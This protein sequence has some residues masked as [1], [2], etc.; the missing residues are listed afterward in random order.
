MN[1]EDEPMTS[2]WR[3]EKEAN[4]ENAKIASGD[5]LIA[6]DVV[7]GDA[8]AV[9]GEALTVE[10]VTDDGGKLEIKFND[11]AVWT[12]SRTTTWRVVRRSTR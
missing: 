9:N 6:K 11:G 8:L 2:R 10:S 5:Y 3:R 12:S 4:R 1:E 7:R